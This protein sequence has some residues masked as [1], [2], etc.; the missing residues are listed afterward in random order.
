MNDLKFGFL[1]RY[2]NGSV[3]RKLFDT[4]NILGGKFCDK[5]VMLAE[6]EYLDIVHR[7]G[8]KNFIF[9]STGFICN[10]SDKAE[11][12]LMISNKSITQR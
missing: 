6:F 9:G 5:V 3:R 8:V 12:E 2:V 10:F 4:L 11:L 7:N 1:V